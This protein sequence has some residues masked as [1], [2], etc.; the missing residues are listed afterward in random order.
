MESQMSGSQWK[1]QSQLQKY[2]HNTHGI[3]FLRRFDRRVNHPL[4]STA[5]NSKQGSSNANGTSEEPL[6]EPTHPVIKIVMS[7]T[8]DVDFENFCFSKN[9]SNFKP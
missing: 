4:Y 5:I 9:C 8:H 3:M 1:T 2:K 6:K 7:S